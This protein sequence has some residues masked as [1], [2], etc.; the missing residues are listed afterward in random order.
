VLLATIWKGSDEATEGG[1]RKSYWFGKKR[2]VS[3]E[4]SILKDNYPFALFF[5]GG[6]GSEMKRN[7]TIR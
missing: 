3:L 1:I 4:D 2:E 7:D 5:K 6:F